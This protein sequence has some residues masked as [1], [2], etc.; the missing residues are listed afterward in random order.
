[1]IRVSEAAVVLPEL[2]FS[3][4]RHKVR[5][6]VLTPPQGLGFLPRWIVELDGD[7]QAS[8]GPVYREGEEEVHTQARIQMWIVKRRKGE[9]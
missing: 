8:L 4:G 1:V 3:L 2:E 9:F 5:A 6:K 7:E